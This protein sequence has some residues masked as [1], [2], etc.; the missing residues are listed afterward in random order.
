MT[1][2]FV[3]RSCLLMPRLVYVE[4]QVQ[5]IA[6]MQIVVALSDSQRN[7][8]HSVAITVALCYSILLYHLLFFLQE[9]RGGAAK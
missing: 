2:T 7:H 9:V 4:V 6:Q 5:M 8:F 1:V 3:L